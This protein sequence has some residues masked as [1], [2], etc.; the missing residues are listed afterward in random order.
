M[1]G[2]I[3]VLVLD[4]EAAVAAV[5]AGLFAELIRRKP[6]AVLGLATGSTP[7]P[8]Y[9]EM[10]HLYRDTG[11]SFA[12][13]RAF[14]LDEYL[15]LDGDQ[16]QSYR[17]F[18]QKRLFDS[19]DICAWNTFIFDG[20]ALDPEQECR[21]YE[22]KIRAVGGVDLWL[23]GIGSNGHIA[24]NEPGSDPASRSRVVTPDAE[25]VKAN[26][27]HFADPSA[28]PTQ[29][30]TAGVGTIL[31]ARQ[32]VLV[33]TGAHKADAVAQALEGPRSSACPASLLQEHP[34]CTFLLDSAAASQLC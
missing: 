2:R 16:D 23:L 19:I 18:M 11:L 3:D 13:T 15:G 12:K 20:T 31:D 14:N 5:A 21:A 27:R 30:M 22:A 24:F 29:A 25:T 7:E 10:V 34:N 32:I 33:A 6:N 17:F 9:A 4:D 26:S 28:V 8:I 1:S